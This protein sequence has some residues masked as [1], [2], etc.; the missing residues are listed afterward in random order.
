VPASPRPRDDPFAVGSLADVAGLRV[1][2]HHRIGRGWQ[3]GTTVVLAPRGAVAAVDVRGGGPGT[4]ETDALDARNLVDR[5]HAVCL[6]GG[7]A[8]GLAA[9][10]GVMAHL[11]HRRLGIR[12]G[13]EPEHVVPVVPTAVIFDLGRGGR[14]GNRPDAGFGQ[15][16][17]SAARPRDIARGA[18]GAGAGARSGG[19]QG[20]VGMASSMLTLAGERITVAALA[21]VNSVG[22]AIDPGSGLPWVSH[23]D[24]RRPSNA[25]RQRWTTAVAPPD[26]PPPPPLNTTIGVVATDA[27]LA[28]PEV[29]RMALSA[30]DGLARA[31]RPAHL[32]VDGDTVFG[33]ST[34]EVAL[35]DSEPAFVRDPASRTAALN[36]LFAAAADVFAIACTDAVLT[37]RTV[38]VVPAYRDLCPTAFR[39][40]RSS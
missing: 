10:D 5:I 22:S 6:T 26:S 11:E 8:Y 40:T 25:D 29:G 30:H 2:H 31:I 19:M 33:M 34:G 17:A 32:L 15:R 37:A 14:F 38:G 12:V 20:G 3:T 21:I 39:R 24:L 9:A 36:A 4:R 27:E 35:V 18:V 23:A 1:G 16:A 28:R 7:S 13:P